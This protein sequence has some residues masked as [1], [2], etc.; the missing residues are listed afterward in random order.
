[1]SDEIFIIA[2]VHRDGRVWIPRKFRGFVNHGDYVQVIP[3]RQGE[4]IRK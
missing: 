4:V 3:L 1:M 2:K